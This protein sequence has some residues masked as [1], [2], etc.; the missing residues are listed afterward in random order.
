MLW[1]GYGRATVVADIQSLGGL[2]HKPLLDVGPVEK[3]DATSSDSAAEASPPRPVSASRQLVVRTAAD[4]G[5][6]VPSE[7]R[8]DVVER[9]GCLWLRGKG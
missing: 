7:T 2:M 8:F 3:D 4:D 5:T 1:S 6:G 9:A